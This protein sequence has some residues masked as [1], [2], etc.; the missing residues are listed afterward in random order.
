MC[1]R[2]L[3]ER[4]SDQAVTALERMVEEG[5]LV[6]A[7]QGREPQRQAGKIGRHRVLVDAV[8]TALRDQAAGMQFLGFVGWDDRPR[9][10]VRPGL[11]EPISQ[12][13]AGLDQEGA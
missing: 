3:V 1:G 7:C 5:E 9:A 13:A 12:L 4:K 11:N 2:D 8:E 10:R 6:L